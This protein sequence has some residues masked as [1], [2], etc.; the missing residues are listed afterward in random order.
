[1]PAIN[2]KTKCKTFAICGFRSQ[3]R[4]TYVVVFQRTAKNVK[5]FITHVPLNLL[6]DDVF[7]AVAVV[8]SSVKFPKARHSL[9]RIAIRWWGRLRQKHEP[10]VSAKVYG[11]VAIMSSEDMVRISITWSL[12][13]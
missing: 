3:I 4:R 10:S 2:S 13:G 5:V 11:Y 1:M 9:E 12:I 8:V 7:V 6:F